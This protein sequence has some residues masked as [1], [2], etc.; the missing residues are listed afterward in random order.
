MQISRLR[1]VRKQSYVSHQ[2]TANFHANIFAKRLSNKS[3]LL[4]GWERIE[5]YQPIEN[6]SFDDCFVQ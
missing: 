4:Y 6:C 5:C 3:L 2:H 1:S